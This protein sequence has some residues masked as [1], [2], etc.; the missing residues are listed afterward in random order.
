LLEMIIHFWQWLSLFCILVILVQ[1]LSWDSFSCFLWTDI[2]FFMERI[3]RKLLCFSWSFKRLKRHEVTLLVF[4]NLNN[5]LCRNWLLYP[6]DDD[7]MRSKHTS[8][9]DG[10]NPLFTFTLL[11]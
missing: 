4:N 1:K 10:D 6:F 7:L 9:D 11:L 5:C 3:L 2:V 8:Q